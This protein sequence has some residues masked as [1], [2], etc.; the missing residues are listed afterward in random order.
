MVKHVTNITEAQK[1]ESKL[2]KITMEFESYVQTL[3][4]EEAQKWLDACNA[5]CVMEHVHGRPFP[6]FKWKK[7]DK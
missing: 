4:G 7:T 1:M 5:T 3:E 6:A 2:I